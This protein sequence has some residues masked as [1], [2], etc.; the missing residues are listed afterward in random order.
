[1]SDFFFTQAYDQVCKNKGWAVDLLQRDSLQ[2][3]ESLLKKNLERKTFFN[4]LLK[5]HKQEFL[6]A[7]LYGP[8]GRGKTLVMDIFYENIP[9]SLKKNRF[10]FH[11]FMQKV[12]ADLKHFSRTSSQDQPILNVVRRIGET[13]HILCLDEVQVTEIADAMLLARLFTGLLEQGIF[14]VMTSNHPPHTL[15]KGGLH[16]ER[17]A[18]FT[19]LLEEKLY[20]ISF[21]E[22]RR[23][24]RRRDEL[25]HQSYFVP[26]NAMTER[27]CEEIFNRLRQGKEIHPVTLVVHHR[28]LIFERCSSSMLWATFSDLCEHPL[29]PGDYLKIAQ[30]FSVIFIMNIPVFCSD[31]QSAAKR[32]MTLIDTLYDHKIHVIMTAAAAPDD[33]YQDT[34]GHKLPFERTAS[35]L[36]EMQLQSYALK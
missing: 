2:T 33:L 21:Q 14:V 5:R 17:F 12:H 36:V 6:G 15:Y 16:Y 20:L 10:H 7:Y 32:F 24:Y 3:L 25:I 4:R 18:P 29:G 30:T 8:V 9:L 11:A 22:G 1:M 35:R 13:T 34:K 27:I 26:H 31:N 19:Q 28:K 23:D